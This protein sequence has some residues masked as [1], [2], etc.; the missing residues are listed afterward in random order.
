MLKDNRND[1]SSITL[2]VGL[3]TL[4]SLFIGLLLGSVPIMAADSP[5]D[6]LVVLQYHHVGSGTPASTSISLSQFEQHL[7]W[8]ASNNFQ[9]VALPEALATLRDGR[10]LPDKTV[11]ITF[12]DGYQDNYTNAYPALKKRGWPF[13]I[14]INPDP[15]DQQLKGWASWDELR[16]MSNNGASIANHTMSHLFMIRPLPNES[17]AAWLERLKQ[18]IVTAE[19]RIEAETGQSHRILAYPYGESN[20]AARQLV[21]GL[22]FM[23]FGQQSGGIGPDSDYTD[24]PRFPLSGIYASLESFKT[25]MNSLPM[26]VYRAAPDSIS[27]DG[28]LKH[29]E[30][31]PA[32]TL[33]L[34]DPSRI[35]LN[36]FASAQGAIPVSSQDEGRYLI[37][38]PDSL[39][40]GRS[41]YNCTYTSAWPGRFYWYSYAW[42]R[43]DENE[44]WTHQ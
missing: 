3:K 24:L 1:Y 38:A 22:S 27:G 17:E 10:S 23:A 15:H 4:T 2:G 37:R 26:P 30:T 32:L 28:I 36:C 25:K 43:R 5:P 20:I 21:A 14:F 34:H 31:R 35:S 7:D 39:P 29:A 18:E 9:V 42:V 44:T 13:T 19:E 33:Q 41:R 6:H 40:V 11:A 12:D 16:E 8:L